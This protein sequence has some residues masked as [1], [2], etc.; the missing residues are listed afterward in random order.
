MPDWVL[1]MAEEAT[2]TSGAALAKRLGYSSSVVSQVLNHR[3]SLGD[4]DRVEAAVRGALM[5]V[6]VVCPVLGEIG[7]D[8]CLMERREPHRATSAMRAQLF[9]ACKTCSHRR[10]PR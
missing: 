9:H 2:R 5:G 6:T 3:Y 4:L 1:V 8:H 10:A 7:R